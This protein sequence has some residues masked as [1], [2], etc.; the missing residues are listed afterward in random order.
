MPGPLDRSILSR[1]YFDVPSEQFFGDDRVKELCGDVSQGCPRSCKQANVNED[2]KQDVIDGKLPTS[3]RQYKRRSHIIQLAVSVLFV[4]A[5]NLY[6]AG[7][8]FS[9]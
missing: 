4:M 6:S 2:C 3:W 8:T 1:L 9:S 5:C 7:S